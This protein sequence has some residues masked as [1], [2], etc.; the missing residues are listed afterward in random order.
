MLLDPA[1]LVARANLDR[2]AAGAREVD[3]D[4]LLRIGAG[5]VPTLVERI[6]ELPEEARC[7][8]AAT[9][10]ERWGPGADRS[11]LPRVD[12]WRAWNAAR[13]AAREAV[14]GRAADLRARA[15]GCG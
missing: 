1:A 7:R 10:L 11:E 14:A 9:L 8:T 13:A 15:E 4:H 3:V 2:A 6:D 5:A 12:D